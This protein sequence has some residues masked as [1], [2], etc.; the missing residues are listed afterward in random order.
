M[1][2]AASATNAHVEEDEVFMLLV[3]AELHEHAA[4]RS[5]MSLICIIRD[6]M[7]VANNN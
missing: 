4:R 6:S 3:K 1:A 5:F 7:L 2:E